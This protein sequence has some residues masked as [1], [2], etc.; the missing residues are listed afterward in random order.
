MYPSI[1]HQ[2]VPAASNRFSRAY[3]DF[4]DSGME[5]AGVTRE[6]DT[7]TQIVSGLKS[8]SMSSSKL[9]I[10]SKGF[11]IDPNAP[12]S[13]NQLTQAVRMVTDSISHLMDVCT[14]SAPGQQECDN[15]LRQMQ[16]G[17]LDQIVSP[18]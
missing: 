16:V 4:M 2:Q 6:R 18:N 3:V 10:Q 11:I 17:L 5:M 8:V 1:L 13:K 14:T 15:A 7:R 12:N 9:L